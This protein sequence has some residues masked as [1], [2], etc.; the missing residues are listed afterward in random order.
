MCHN[1]V[2]NS[3]NGR[4][5]LVKELQQLKQSDMK[6]CC[7][8]HKLLNM[9]K[10]QNTRS[11]IECYDHRERRKTKS[12]K[13]FMCTRGSFSCLF[14]LYWFYRQIIGQCNVPVVKNDSFNDCEIKINHKQIFYGNTW[15]AVSEKKN[16]S[17]IILVS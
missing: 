14:P 3:T 10:S 12:R 16:V 7:L 6:S 8:S 17:C 5:H 11:G 9:F 15:C 2:I 4:Y 1:L 13:Q